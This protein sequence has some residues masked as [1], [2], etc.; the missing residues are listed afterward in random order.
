LHITSAQKFSNGFSAPLTV[1]AQGNQRNNDSLWCS[2]L[3]HSGSVVSQLE[4]RQLEFRVCARS[5]IEYDGAVHCAAHHGSF[6]AHHVIRNRQDAGSKPISRKTAKSAWRAVRDFQRRG[7]NDIEVI[8]HDGE[9]LA[10][11]EL[12]QRAAVERGD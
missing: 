3:N 10:L 5:G 6:M 9:P 2:S 7:L 4:F 1:K 12:S 8:D 11:E